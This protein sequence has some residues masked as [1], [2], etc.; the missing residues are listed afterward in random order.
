MQNPG[1]N[2]GV[3][4]WTD[5]ADGRYYTVRANDGCN[6]TL[7]KTHHARWDILVMH[8]ALQIYDGVC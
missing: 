6:F 5:D 2:A 3:F 7:K 1:S 8:T 4:V